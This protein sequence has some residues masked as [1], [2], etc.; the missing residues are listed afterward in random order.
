MIFHYLLKKLAIYYTKNLGV[1]YDMFSD[2]DYML[3][4]ASGFQERD[5]LVWREFSFH[6]SFF[7]N[8]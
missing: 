2:I 8:N 7:S 6:P 3:A 5:K 1:I 4:H